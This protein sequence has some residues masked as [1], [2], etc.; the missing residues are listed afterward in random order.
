MPG[1]VFWPCGGGHPV[2][3]PWAAH[4]VG[5]VCFRFPV[6]LHHEHWAGWCADPLEPLPL[7]IRDLS[8]GAYGCVVL[9]LNT[10]TGQQVALKFIEHG[11]EVRPGLLLSVARL[12]A[13]P[14]SQVLTHPLA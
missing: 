1:W 3:A 14:S 6:A 13:M 5:P 2:A 4:G 10:Q 7:Q 9:A 8:R 11:K 12:K